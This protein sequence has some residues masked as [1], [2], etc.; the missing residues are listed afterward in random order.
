[1]GS[2]QTQPHPGVPRPVPAPA[3][4]V[5][6][7]RKHYAIPPEHGA[8]FW[9]LGPLFLGAA[10]APRPAP[11]LAVLTGAALAAFLMRQPMVLLVKVWS[12]RRGPNDRYP[13]QFWLSVYGV[14]ALAA[15]GGLVAL[16][17]GRVLWLALP[18][19]PIFG[20]FLW[21]VSRRE[22]RGRMAL[23]IAGAA[24]LALTAPAAYW[25]CGG[26]D[27]IV[28]WMVWGLMVL[29][30]AASIVETYLRLEQRRLKSLPSPEERWLRAAPALTFHG[31]NLVAVG[32]LALAG[33]APGLAPAAFLWSLLGALAATQWPPVGVK[34]SRVGIR[35]LVS[36]I[37]FVAI[38]VL[39]YRI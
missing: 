7:W 37:L 19:I 25:V 18:A 32:M 20:Y 2:P 30:I 29:H 34:P 35:Q 15:A 6:V 10:A 9:L 21:R 23:E 27:D 38:M 28:A 26:D 5:T 11:D 36:S 12:G 3:R 31:S 1:M 16:G 39:A 17:H 14:L 13:A 24:V 33:W 4:P 8:W 22:E